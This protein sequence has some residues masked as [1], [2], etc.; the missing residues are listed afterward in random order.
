VQ[1]KLHQVSGYLPAT[2]EAY[3]L[4]KSSGFYEKN[5]GRETPIQQMTGKEPTANSRGIRLINMPQVRDIQ[6]EEF[7]KMLSGGQTAQQALDNAVKRGNAAIK[8]A[9]GQ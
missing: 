3:Q 5:P 2:M 6:N 9:A 1:A 4:T 7:E 8:Q